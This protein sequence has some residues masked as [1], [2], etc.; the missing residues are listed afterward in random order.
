MNLN[1]S[2]SGVDGQLARCTILRTLGRAAK[3]TTVFKVQHVILYGG[4]G[5]VFCPWRECFSALQC[6]GLNQQLEELAP[7][8][9]HGRQQW[10]AHFQKF[11]IGGGWAGLAQLPNRTAC[12]IFFRDNIAPVMG[13]GVEK[14]NVNFQPLA[15]G[16]ECRQMHGRQSR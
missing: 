4:Q 2:I 9:A 10:V 5:A 13:A 15:K 6:L 1:R 12:Q 11:F 8:F 7:L 3:S 14:I 16:L